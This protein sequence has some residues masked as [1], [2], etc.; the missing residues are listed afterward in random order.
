[1]TSS[2]PVIVFFCFHLYLLWM[3]TLFMVKVI[4][5]FYD[6]S[7]EELQ[8]VSQGP[9]P[10]A[11]I[12]IFGISRNIHCSSA[13][14]SIQKHQGKLEVLLSP[15]L[16]HEHTFISPFHAH[17]AR[18]F[19]LFFGVEWWWRLLVV[20]EFCRNL[21]WSVGQPFVFFSCGKPHLMCY[22]EK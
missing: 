11:V 21:A 7:T 12:F 1:M 18:L 2:T 4:F 6:L 17:A 14:T 19:H 20:G 15:P 8:R 13:I 5:S 10:D 16:S 9:L 3:C 22:S